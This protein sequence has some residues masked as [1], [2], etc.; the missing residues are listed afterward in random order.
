MIWRVGRKVP[1]NVYDG[2]RPVCQCHNAEDAALIVAAME[3]DAKLA[4]ARELVR[5]LPH[6]KE[7]NM[8]WARS[9][10]RRALGCTCDRGKILA[11]LGEG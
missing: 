2:D 10:E 9:H 8:Y 3:R 1:I 4:A 7:C 11:V 6:N 5:E